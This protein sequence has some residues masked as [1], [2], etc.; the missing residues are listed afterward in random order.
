MKNNVIITVKS[1]YLAD[2]S[3]PQKSYF[4][5]S[6]K[7]N[8][9][10]KRADSVRLISRYWNIIDGDGNNEDIYGPGVVGQQPWIKKNERFEYTSYCPLK[11]PIGKMGG[12]ITDWT[13]DD[14]GIPLSDSKRRGILTEEG[15][16]MSF[17]DY[18]ADEVE[19]PRKTESEK[20]QDELEPIYE[21]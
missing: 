20:M 14:D 10:N 8:I 3:L 1:K 19:G 12:K 16:I 13:I 2:K 15:M 21:E 9:L 7:V 4:L 6:Y 17:F 5:F 18:Y 11:T